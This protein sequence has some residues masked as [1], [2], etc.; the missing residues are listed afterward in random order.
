[1]GR[2]LNYRSGI[3]LASKDLELLSIPTIKVTDNLITEAHA[4]YLIF[5][6][7]NKESFNSIRN[8]WINES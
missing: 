2:S 7:T 4:V 5:D 3:L 1:M 6:L 8:Y